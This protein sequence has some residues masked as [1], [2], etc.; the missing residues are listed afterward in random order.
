MTAQELRKEYPQGKRKLPLLWTRSYSV[1]SGG[2]FPKQPVKNTLKNNKIKSAFPPTSKE[3]GL[4]RRSPV[5]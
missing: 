5:K 2:L 4:S 1:E 3:G